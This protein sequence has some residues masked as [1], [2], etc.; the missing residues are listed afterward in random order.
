MA[1]LAPLTILLGTDV[2]RGD[3]LLSLSGGFAPPLQHTGEFERG[4]GSGFGLN[5]A[6]VITPAPQWEVGLQGGVWRWSGQD[7]CGPRSRGACGFESLTCV[8]MTFVVRH[9]LG[10]AA[11]L[12]YFHAEAGPHRLAWGYKDDAWYN[13]HQEPES[14]LGV[15]V[16]GGGRLVLSAA[17]CIDLGLVLTQLWTDPELTRYALVLVGLTLGARSRCRRQ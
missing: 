5:V 7:D 13:P 1:F 12:F 16:G 3:A 6:F 9:R 4:T 8:P 11:P 2:A 14:P 17:A 10:R 15:G